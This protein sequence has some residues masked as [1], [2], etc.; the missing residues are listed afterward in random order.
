GYR[1]DHVIR[2]DKLDIGK[3]TPVNT[4]Q[5]KPDLRTILIFQE[6]QHTLH[7]ASLSEPKKGRRAKHW[8]SSSELKGKRIVYIKMRVRSGKIAQ[9]VRT[10][11]VFAFD[12][13]TQTAFAEVRV[14]KRDRVA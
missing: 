6:M 10:Q 5:L 4:S 7:F 14:D 2:V 3:F 13:S 8:D 1:E 11:K 12:Q 9:T